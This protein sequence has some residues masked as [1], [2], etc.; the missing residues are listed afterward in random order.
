MKTQIAI[1]NPNILVK[2]CYV[3]NAKIYESK[4]HG[5]WSDKTPFIEIIFRNTMDDGAINFKM[6]LASYL[7]IQDEECNLNEV[8]FSQD[9]FNYQIDT[10]TGERVINELKTTEIELTV[11][12]MF[13]SLGFNED[14]EVSI[15][16]IVGKSALLTIKNNR[17]TN[18]K[19]K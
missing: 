1:S 19:R 16:D 15:N 9:S 10:K 3:W 12:K 2:E 7:T 14:D 8:R 13:Y 17:V 18:L 11:R 5:E 6:K 4:E